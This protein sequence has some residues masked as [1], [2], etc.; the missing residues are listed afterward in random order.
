MMKKILNLLLILFL[1]DSFFF[2]IILN[3]NESFAESREV[4]TWKCQAVFPGPEKVLGFWGVFG[5]T[6]EVIRRVNTRTNGRFIIKHFMPGSI[7]IDPYSALNAVKKGVVDMSVGGGVYAMGSVPEARIQQMGL[8]YG[9][10]NHH[11]AS[12]LILKTDFVKILRQAYFERM[13]VNLIGIT[14]TGST[15]FITKFPIKNLDSLKGKKIRSLAGQVKI[16]QLHGAI[17]V[18]IAP[19]E[20]YMALQQGTID[21]LIFPPYTGISYKIFEVSKYVMEPFLSVFTG[22]DWVTN[23]DS[24]N[25]LPKEFQNILL[26]EVD[27]MSRFTYEENGPKLDEYVKEEG[28]KNWGAKY[29]QLPKHEFVKFRKLVIP[30]WDEL[31]NSSDLSKKLITII[32]NVIENQ[33]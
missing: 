5:Q 25:K 30:I 7:G 28:E 23:I 32:K 6:A 2:L 29:I 14:G 18:T 15:T 4:I 16:V 33:K 19:A 26:E 8:P 3:Q 24:W 17:P 20:L 11:Q 21:G 12:H 1:T 31:E 13:Q 27:K 9:L 22:M 10:T